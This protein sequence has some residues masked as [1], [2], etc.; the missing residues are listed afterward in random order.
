M[1]AMLR[2]C[3]VKSCLGGQK[4]GR[5]KLCARYSRVLIPREKQPG[6]PGS[7]AEAANP[8]AHA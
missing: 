1:A 4:T 2:V 5:S 8:L 6:N 7:T 3:L